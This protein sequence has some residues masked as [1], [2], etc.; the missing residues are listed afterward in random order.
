MSDLVDEQEWVVD[1]RESPLSGNGSLSY[2]NAVSAAIMSATS[3]RA[4]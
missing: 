4:V 2:G 3:V 1:C